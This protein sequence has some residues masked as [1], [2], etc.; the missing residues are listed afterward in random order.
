MLP[1]SLPTRD[2]SAFLRCVATSVAH[3][4]DATQ[5]MGWGGGESDIE[6]FLRVSFTQTSFF[7]FPTSVSEAFLTASEI[8]DDSQQPQLESFWLQDLQ[9]IML[10]KGIARYKLPGH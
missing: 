3:M 7:A 6:S 5:Q 9:A 10:P 1:A 2:N 8:I 4:V